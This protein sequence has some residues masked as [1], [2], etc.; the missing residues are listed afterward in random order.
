[1]E[2]L[3]VPVILLTQEIVTKTL[4]QV[5]DYQ[6]ALYEFMQWTLIF[7]TLKKIKHEKY[8]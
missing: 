6:N 4:V 2:S 8:L 5:S 3:I 7:F 1:M